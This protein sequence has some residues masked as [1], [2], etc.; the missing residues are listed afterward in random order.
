MVSDHATA[1]TDQTAI[2]KIAALW[3]QE[4]ARSTTWTAPIR[5]WRSILS[6]PIAYTIVGTAT[7]L[8]SN[9]VRGLKYSASVSNFTHCGI[10]SGDVA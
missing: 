3:K 4:V 6:P 9:Q 2:D 1:G 7:D 5:F 10:E 8:E